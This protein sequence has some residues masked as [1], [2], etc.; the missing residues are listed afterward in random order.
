MSAILQDS[1]VKKQMSACMSCTIGLM[2]V[3]Q[4]HEWRAVAKHPLHCT[5]RYCHA[6]P[7]CSKH[8][9]CASK[10]AGSSCCSGPSAVLTACCLTPGS[11]WSPSQ[12]RAQQPL[13]SAQQHS[14]KQRTSSQHNVQFSCN[15][16]FPAG[17]I[18]EPGKFQ[19]LKRDRP[20]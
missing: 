1:S 13:W 12:T 7:V 17:R 9:C 20:N 18:Q 2:Q 5:S 8:I 19:L 6:S 11:S 15:W 16:Q 4:L 3:P 14:R 10:V